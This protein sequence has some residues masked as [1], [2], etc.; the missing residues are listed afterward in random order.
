[1]L[2]TGYALP[3]R[4]HPNTVILAILTLAT[5]G[6]AWF[7]LKHGK[8]TPVEAFAFVTGALCVWLTVKESAWNFPFSL[9]SPAA[10]FIVFFRAHLFADM[11]LQVVFFLLTLV[12]WYLWLF[13]GQR[14]TALRVSRCTPMGILLAGL[15]TIALTA[16]WWG[17]LELI[18]GSATF[19]DALLTALSLTAQWL[20][21]SKRL[22]NWHFWILADIVSIPLYIYKGLY[23]TALLYG[24]FLIMATMGYFAWRATWRRQQDSHTAFPVL[25]PEAA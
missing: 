23:L 22:E 11:S 3:M 18:N 2:P 6:L 15:S 7:L 8:T 17:L 14:H 24:I 19:F 4:L 5:T 12:G 25:M 9:L 10:F 20:L 16:A 1:M 13:G 21:N